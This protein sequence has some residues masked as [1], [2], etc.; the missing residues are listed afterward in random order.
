MKITNKT[1]KK[2]SKNELRSF[3]LLMGSIS[4]VFTAVFFYKAMDKAAIILG[5][6]SMGFF[7]TGLAI[8][9]LLMGIYK[10][11]MKF[12]FILGNFNMKIILGFIYLT[13]FSTVRL[14]FLILR[15]DPL[16]RRLDPKVN[17]YWVNH[18]ETEDDP[19]RF[20]KQY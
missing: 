12:S 19:S 15:K 10:R 6:S 9:K 8:P 11:W 14:I 16:R 18:P 7:G 17:T 4:A 13:G 20:E 1:Q 2:H 3:G 5:F